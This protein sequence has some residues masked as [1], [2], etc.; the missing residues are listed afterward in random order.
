LRGGRER[1]EVF[2]PLAIEGEDAAALEERLAKA[3]ATPSD[4]SA[5]RRELGRLESEILRELRRANGEAQRPGRT[6]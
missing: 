4:E 1:A 3:Q 5:V 6:P 2:T